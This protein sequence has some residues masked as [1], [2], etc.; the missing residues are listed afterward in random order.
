M[1]ACIHACVYVCIDQA[2]V[3]LLL[4]DYFKVLFG[5]WFGASQ[6]S[7]YLNLGMHA[8]IHECVYDIF[9][10]EVLCSY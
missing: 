2:R 1:R 7:P 8:C 4:L 5:V 6:D 9:G 3:N 10:L